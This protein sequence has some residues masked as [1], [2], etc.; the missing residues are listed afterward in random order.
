MK[1][2]Y[3]FAI[4]LLLSI[5]V[6]QISAQKKRI[7]LF[8]DFTSGSIQMKNKSTAKGLFNYDTSN[9]VMMFRDKDEDMI[10]TNSQAV[11]TAFI[12][13]RKFIP[14][15]RIYLEVVA[16]SSDFLYINWHYKEYYQGKKGAFG[17]TTQSNVLTINTNHFQPG[18][19]YKTQS[20]DVNK[21]AN[22]N[23]YWFFREGKP[24]KFKNKKTLLKLFPGKE[25]VIENFMKEN[26]TDMSITEHVIKLA[27]YCTS[28]KQR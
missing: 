16:L 18:T 27:D 22:E 24:V 3:T 21:Q 15:N 17:Q 2:I 8:N 12:G 14:V 23:E 5:P 7:F 11:D 1:S 25:S 13:T 19:D 20:A 28:L 26:H 9:R 6:C 10:L 4:L